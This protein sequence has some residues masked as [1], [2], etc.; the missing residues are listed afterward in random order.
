MGRCFLS[1]SESLWLASFCYGIDSVNFRRY[2]R[3]APLIATIRRDSNFWHG[4]ECDV[5]GKTQ[6]QSRALQPRSGDST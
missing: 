5:V 6:V 4:L 2:T 3:E 1:V